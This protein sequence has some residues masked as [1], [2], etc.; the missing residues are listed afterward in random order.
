MHVGRA[1]SPS[2]HEKRG[3]GPNL[4]YDWVSYRVKDANETEIGFSIIFLSLRFDLC[5]LTWYRQVKIH[6][7]HQFFEG[8]GEITDE[9]G[10]NFS[11]FIS[12]D[13]LLEGIDR[14]V[15]NGF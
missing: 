4:H 12:P 8:T 15:C 10:F 3:A 2:V 14:C 13:G 11:S 9:S 1:R 6:L 7:I 5:F